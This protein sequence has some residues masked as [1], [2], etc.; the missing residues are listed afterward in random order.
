MPVT[1][2]IAKRLAATLVDVMEACERPSPAPSEGQGAQFIFGHKTNQR[3]VAAIIDESP[4][5]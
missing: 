1:G 5:G 3:V 2:K 4:L